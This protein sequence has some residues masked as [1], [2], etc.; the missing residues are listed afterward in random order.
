MPESEFGAAA[1]Y[2]I[3]KK[4]GAQRVGEDAIK[5]FRSAL[6]EIGLDIAKRAVEFASHAGRKTVKSSDVKLAIKTYL[7]S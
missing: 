3:F 5:E 6:E 4:A 1:I 2:R 7:S